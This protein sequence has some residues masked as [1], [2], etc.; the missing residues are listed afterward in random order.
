MTV[1]VYRES[2]ASETDRERVS[3]VYDCLYFCFFLYVN[4]GDGDGKD[5]RG[6]GKRG[7]LGVVCLDGLNMF[8]FVCARVVNSTLKHVFF[9]WFLTVSLNGNLGQCEAH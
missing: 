1:T 8:V 7:G 3:R 2:V 6:N 9:V 5:A 4:G